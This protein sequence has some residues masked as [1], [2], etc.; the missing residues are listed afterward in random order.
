MA[1]LRIRVRKILL[2][3]IIFIDYTVYNIYILYHNENYMQNLTF[4][5]QHQNADASYFHEGHCFDQVVTLENHVNG[6]IGHY[7]SLGD[8]F[9]EASLLTDG[10]IEWR[11]GYT[12]RSAFRTD[13][14]HEL[15]LMG[16]VA[17]RRED[18]VQ[19][20]GREVGGCSQSFI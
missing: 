15:D 14:H 20:H 11:C 5:A 10:L 3:G 7:H 16:R 8:E 12:A 13:A 17:F 6:F 2:V 4:T 18:K 1:K 9:G 19:R